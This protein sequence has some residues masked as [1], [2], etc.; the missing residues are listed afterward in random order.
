MVA[1]L[2]GLVPGLPD[3]LATSIRTRAEGIPL[4]AV[5]TVRMLLDQG[6]L[7]Q[8]IINLAV[9]A[10]D[11][12][13]RGGSLRLSSCNLEVNS[14]ESARL[15]A[16]GPGRY[17][18]LSVRD[19]GTGM[20]PETQRRIFEPFFTTKPAGEGTGLGLS[21]VHGVVVKHGGAIRVHSMK[22]RGTTFE[23]YFPLSEAKEP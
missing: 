3:E 5:E 17:V 23:I 21:I 15:G 16:I 14:A 20:S 10:R 18:V 19:T 2:D 13:P 8:V 4:Y 12:M 6:Q 7:E 22:D 11:A 9:N 1:L